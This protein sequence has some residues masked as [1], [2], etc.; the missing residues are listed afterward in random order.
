[1]LGWSWIVLMGG[2]MDGQI[3]MDGRMDELIDWSIDSWM[4]SWMDG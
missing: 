1:M 4:Q 2:V 3:V